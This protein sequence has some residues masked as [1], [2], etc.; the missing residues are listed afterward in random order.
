[1]TTYEYEF[2][3]K[4]NDWLALFF[5]RNKTC[6]KCKVRVKRK[7]KTVDLGGGM[8]WERD[9]QKFSYGHKEKRLL[10][11]RYECPNCQER[12]MPSVLW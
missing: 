12:Y 11:I 4:L 5:R 8:G 2:D 6:P 7:T 10:E 9:G 3:L 1:M